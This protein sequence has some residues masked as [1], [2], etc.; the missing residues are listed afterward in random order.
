[1]DRLK[2]GFFGDGPWAHLAL[3]KLT[4]DITIQ[5]VFVC[6]RFKEP[7]KILVE[8]ASK[9]GIQTLS[10]QEINHPTAIASIS[11][12][13]ADLFVS[14]SFNQIF[15]EIFLSS[16]QLGVVNCH[17]GK[18]PF[19]R[20]RNVLNWVLINDEKEFGITVH[21][22]DSGIDTGDII[23]QKSFPIT[24]DDDYQTLLNRASIDCA[25]ILYDGIK[26]IQAGK[27]HRKPQS[28]ID[29]LGS[30][31]VKRKSGDEFIDWSQS[32]R[33]IFNFVRAICIPGPVARTW[34]GDKMVRINEVVYIPTA[35]KYVG[36]PGSVI[37][38]LPDGF[39]IKTGDT[40]L[41][42]ISWYGYEN[43]SIGDRFN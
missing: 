43:P 17:A 19:Y 37:G 28:E 3:D 39:L 30:Y 14:M 8:K 36:I 10:F 34:C 26:L 9:L 29:S 35:E 11:K 41:K 16:A 23:I 2:V 21:Y 20:G 22:V 24:D 6:T 12:F 40:F 7:D 33:A 5:V 42:A 1:M 15:K 18:L 4:T 13:K 31:H 32:S 27:V 25:E 38:V